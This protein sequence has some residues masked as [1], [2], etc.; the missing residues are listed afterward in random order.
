MSAPFLKLFRFFKAH[1]AFFYIVLITTTL[2]FGYMAGRLHFEEDILTLLPQTDS[3][4]DCSV[5]FGEIKVKDNLFLE[6]MAAEGFSA[7]ASEL[8][9]AIDEFLSMLTEYD[10]EGYIG[11]CL[12]GFDANDI[13]NLV[14][15][16]MGALPNHLGEGF[17]TLLDSLMNEQTIDDIASGK[18]PFALPDM[19]SYTVIDGHL[20]SK[21]STLAVAFIQPGFKATD[22]KNGT[23]FEAKLN[24]CA[25]K[26]M[27]SHPEYEVLYHG[28]LVESVFNSRQIKK[29]LVWSVGVSILLV[30]IIILISFRGRRTIFLLLMPVI[31]GTIFSMA[32]VW[33]I[34]GTLSIISIGIGAL[35]LG[36][37]LSY[38]LHVLTHYK[39]VTDPEVVLREQTRPVILGCL[40]TVGA[41]AGLF[42]TTS[43]L[44]KDFGLF[45]S[46]AMIGTTLFALVFLPHFFCQEKN[47][48]NERVF[49]LIDR[50]N[51]Y[52]FDR[53]LPV[54]IATLAI[55]VFSLIYAHNV[56]FDSNL[57]HI[58]YREPRI[59]RSEAIF[60]DKVN[61][62]HHCQYYAATSTDM[63]SAIMINRTLGN[64]LD[65]LLK[66]GVIYGYSST[67]AI[68]VPEEEQ[69]ENIE[70]W[71]AYWTPEKVDRCY[72][73]LKGAAEKYNWD[74]GG[75][76][77][78]IPETFKLMAE[79]DYYPKQIYG[80]GALPEAFITNF[81]EQVGDKWLIMSSAHIDRKDILPVSDEI[82]EGKDDVVVL[83]PFYYTG[84]MVEIV[85]DDF[86]I[87]LLI[88]SLF[89]L[90]VLLLSF[91]SIV[92][93]LIA[94]IPMFL[95]WYIVQGLMALFGIDFNLINI[96]VS[97]FIFGIG[98]DYS[99]FV[100]DGL[101]SGVTSSD[102]RLLTCHK[103]AIFFSGITLVIVT[104]SL[105][106][107]VHPAIYSI[108]ISTLIG[109][110]STIILTYVLEP[111]FFHLAMRSSFIR[112]KSLHLR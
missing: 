10:E 48:R 97:S 99:I 40:T 109:M 71:K 96:M 7:T 94:F 81:V 66:A 90:A 67:N 75:L 79:S 88:S 57:G 15:Y 58:G 27:E 82:L 64:R 54:V 62:S 24:R 56:K 23:Y 55:C 104:A 42:L 53:N 59:V 41:F 5:A 52:R 8:A 50:F 4:D 74:T 92:I 60:N 98:V 87:V 78:D 111:L 51:S 36:V 33:L 22:S 83:D 11:S 2:L 25:H 19:G 32:A 16:G 110:V 47:D 102:D 93:S 29:D 107:A 35:V 34:K 89:V 17:Y 12:S 70:R 61:H 95:S 77:I 65:S 76:G 31:Y 80:S 85:H 91:R 73:L 9:A 106:F 45:A 68:L 108:G 26:F 39:Y 69:I 44:L 86:S 43:P 72:K 21:D 28:S 14:Y 6:V 100:M 46:F 49:E 38:C 84:D 101:I 18:L 20:F 103:A 112:K 63:D 3:S 30:C 1:R 13:M 37:A 105:L